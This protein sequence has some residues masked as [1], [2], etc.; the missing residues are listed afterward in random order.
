MFTGTRDTVVINGKV[1]SYDFDSMKQLSHHNLHK[2][3]IK[4]VAIS[5]PSIETEGK[6]K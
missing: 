6:A 2:T 1:C 3:D 5:I 4:R